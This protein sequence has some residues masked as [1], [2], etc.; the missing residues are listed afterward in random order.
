VRASAGV[1]AGGLILGGVAGVFAERANE[2]NASANGIVASSNLRP[3]RVVGVNPLSGP[4][5][6]DGRRAEQGMKLAISEINARGGVLNHK[7]EYVAVD[8]G[9]Y[10]IPQNVT[11]AFN[12]A[13]GQERP[14]VIIG[15]S[16]AAMGPDLDIS[17]R[18]GVI[19][20]DG[21]TRE[22]WRTIYMKDPKKY[23][24]VFQA[25]PAESAYGSGGAKFF[26]DLV[27]SGR[28]KAK[29]KT[30]AMIVGNDAYDTHIADV[31]KKSITG[32][33]WKV[34]FS[35]SVTPQSVPDWG[36]VL[37]QIR[38]NPP[39]LVFTTDFNAADDAAMIKNWASSP[40]PALFYQ[41]YGPSVPQYLQLAGEAGNGVIW[42]TVLGLIPDQIGNRFTERFK[43][44]F[45]TAPSLAYSGA[46]YD[47]IYWWAQAVSAA[48]NVADTRAIARNL[49]QLRW[50]GV[51]GTV[52]MG[53]WEGSKFVQDHTVPSYPSETTD[54]SLGQPDLVFQI[55]NGQ[56]KL[57]SPDP[58]TTAS[59]QLPSWFK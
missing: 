26:N 7:L 42:S 59:F 24:C 49:E 6:D 18:A 47:W 41:Q 5:A 50:R 12:R 38:Q 2:T 4:Q 31:F 27:D 9:D 32:F 35:G 25:D 55:Q 22:D 23:W 16:S 39:A 54:P 20:I 28:Y 37:A 57:L 21:N 29:D 36:P 52:A 3:L 19:Y 40:L 56:Q 8:Q 45:N 14:D 13:V 1:G 17:A 34:T 11:N 58:Y 53:R 33:G 10:T 48:G 44:T 46:V 30:V 15:I 51:D 43:K